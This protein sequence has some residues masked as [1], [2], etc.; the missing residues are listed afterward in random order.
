MKSEEF[1]RLSIDAW[2]NQTKPVKMMNKKAEFPLTF[3]PEM[4]SHVLE[5][6]YVG[7]NLSMLIILPNEIQDET[8]GLQKVRQQRLYFIQHLLTLLKIKVPKEFF[9]QW[10]HRRTIF[11]FPKNLSVNS[12]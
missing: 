4:D 12:S 7:K 11:G 6:P 5:L 3:I 1:W 9:L 2:Q 8:T 10:R